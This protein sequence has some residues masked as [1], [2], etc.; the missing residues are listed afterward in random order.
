[1]NPSKATEVLL[2]PSQANKSFLM[3]H[4]LGPFSLWQRIN[5]TVFSAGTG[6]FN[7]TTGAFTRTGIAGNQ[8]FVYGFDTAVVATIR[9]S[10]ASIDRIRRSR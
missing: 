1:M 4:P 9:G 6:T 8:L 2:I 3:M 7:L 5:G 10:A